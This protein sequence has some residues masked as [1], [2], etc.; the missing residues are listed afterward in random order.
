MGESPVPFQSLYKSPVIS[1]RFIR[2]Q[3][4]DKPFLSQAE[5]LTP[6]GKMGQEQAFVPARSYAYTNVRCSCRR[7]GV[8]EGAMNSVC[9]DSGHKSAPGKS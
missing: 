1:I 9:S 3:R 8:N 6:F 4:M 2:K 5:R 7:S